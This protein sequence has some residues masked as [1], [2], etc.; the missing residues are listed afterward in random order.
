MP[1]TDN[2]DSDLNSS[3]TIVTYLAE[4][5]EGQNALTLCIAV[6]MVIVILVVLTCMAT[7]AIVLFLKKSSQK[8][9]EYDVSYSTLCREPNKQ[10]Q[11]Q[12]IHTPNDLYDRIELSPSTGQAE[13]V[14]KTET[15]NT[16]NPSPHQ[17]QHNIYPSVDTE[18]PKT[19][20]MQTI[21][22]NSQNIPSRANE[23]MFEQPTYAVVN[24]KEKNIKKKGPVYCSIRK[25]AA[26]NPSLTKQNAAEG[27]II[28]LSSRNNVD[29]EWLGSLQQNATKDNQKKLNNDL[30]DNST[31]SLTQTSDSPE[32]LYTAVRKKTK[33]ST[34]H[35]EEELPPIPPQ[36]VEQLYTA[37]NKKTQTTT[38]NDEE[39][40]P[41]IPPQTV[42]ELYTAVMKKPKA[43]ETDD[44]VE[45]PPVPPHTVE[46][47]YT[48]VRKNK[49]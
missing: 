21:V 9:S 27:A 12:S 14:V 22:A 6:G 41:P 30:P 47:L 35:N 38:S 25:S 17:C 24:K 32:E 48:A 16:N 8:E 49:K 40:S 18:Q 1:T 34:A 3:N 13:F 46:E 23:S 28:D 20:A 39:K 37:V 15:D 31:E 44:E 29:Q 45:A 5:T 10:L 4:D 33:E 36:R 2:T 42:E 26:A 7:I 19:S 11:P 43:R